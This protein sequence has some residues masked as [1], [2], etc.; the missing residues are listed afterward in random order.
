[1]IVFVT[2]LGTMVKKES[3]YVGC[4]NLIFA[5]PAHNMPMTAVI[6]NDR[7]ECVRKSFSDKG[8]TWPET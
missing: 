6:M 7:T 8:E 4:S 3:E 1:M 5:I 2:H